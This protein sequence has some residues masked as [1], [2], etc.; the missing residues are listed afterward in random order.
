MREKSSVTFRGHKSSVEFSLL[1]KDALFLLVTCDMQ[2]LAFLFAVSNSS[3][4]KLG[5]L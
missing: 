2:G 4:E 1:F 5:I 3:F